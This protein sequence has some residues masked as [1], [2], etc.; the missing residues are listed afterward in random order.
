MR[1]IGRRDSFATVADREAREPVVARPADLDGPPCGRMS[2]RVV[3]EIGRD[4]AECVLVAEDRDVRRT[5][6]GERDSL[7][8]DA[9]AK[10][11][12]RLLEELSEIDLVSAQLEP[13]VLDPAE[14]EQFV[15]HPV[16][17]ARLLLR[18]RYVA[19]GAAVT[20]K[21]LEVAAQEGQRR[22]Q[23]VCDRRDEEAALLIG[24]R[25]ALR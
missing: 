15:D 7:L 14:R 13:A 12:R 20:R 3:E 16:E 6:R 19:G 2:H 22:A 17:P 1:Q 10:L 8:V 9:F 24:P 21:S 5:G 25:V 23:V 18:S 11:R 4:A